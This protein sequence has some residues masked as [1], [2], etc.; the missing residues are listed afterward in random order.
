MSELILKFDTTRPKFRHD[1]MEKHLATRCLDILLG[2]DAACHPEAVPFEPENKRYMIGCG[3]D[4]WLY[5]TADKGTYRLISRYTETER[6]MALG[7]C[8]KA[9]SFFGD[10]LKSAEMPS[11][12]TPA[13]AP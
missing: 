1:G 9:D 13:P 3:N 12:R 5:R 11:V 7:A 2:R 6:L 10:I 8:L 4:F